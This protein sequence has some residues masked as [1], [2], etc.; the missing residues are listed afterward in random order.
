MD[1][2]LELVGFL[3]GT[4]ADL[5]R[6]KEGL[7][8]LLPS[9]MIPELACFLDEWIDFCFFFM[10]PLSDTLTRFKQV[11]SLFGRRFTASQQILPLGNSLFHSFLS[12]NWPVC[13]I[14]SF[15]SE[16]LDPSGTPTN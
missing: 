1:S 3:V 8:D 11:N 9:Y 12:Q 5:K 4:E 6:V 16:L 14:T 15:A 13:S 10:C 2:D 7:G